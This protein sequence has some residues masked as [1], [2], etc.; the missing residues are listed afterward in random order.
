MGE[1]SLIED[2]YENPTAD[3]VNVEKLNAF[4]PK[5][6]EKMVASFATFLQHCIGDSIQFTKAREKKRHTDWNG[7]STNVFR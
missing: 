3:I 6:K 1:L 4:P 7:R 2:I 5:N